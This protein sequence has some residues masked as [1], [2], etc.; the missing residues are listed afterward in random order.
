M[1]LLSVHRK[2]LAKLE[3]VAFDFASHH[4]DL[5]QP[6]ILSNSIVAFLPRV[7]R[8]LIMQIH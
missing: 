1:K 3:E 8:S 5:V 6:V 7:S 2:T 4:V